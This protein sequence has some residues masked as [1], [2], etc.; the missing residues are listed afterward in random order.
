[1]E[2]IK[3]LD[4]REI[5]NN[6]GLN[7]LSKDFFFKPKGDQPFA[8]SEPYRTETYGIALVLDG[9]IE[10]RADLKHYYVKSPSII[11]MGPEIIR[12]WFSFEGSIVTLNVFF[13]EQF[14]VTGKS[15]VLFLK[16]FEFF[17]KSGTHYL[18]IDKRQ[19]KKFEYLF[20]L[21]GEK[22]ISQDKFKLSTI[23]SLT[24]A[25]LFEIEE[26][27]QRKNQREIRQLSPRELLVRKFMDLLV[28]KFQKH[29]AVQFYADRLFIN[30]KYLSQALKTE[31]GM[32]AS[33]WINE[34]VMLEAKVLLQE[35]KLTIKQITYQ[36]NFADPSFFG[37]FFKR[38]EGK[39]PRQYRDHLKS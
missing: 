17:G 16:K 8:E 28:E 12:Q 19:L 34:M 7:G 13:K 15:D 27:Y 14:L 32:T 5:E 18:S 24:E 3:R 29:R 39:S 38:H 2:E 30:S 26:I 6:F 4:L 20:K 10:L 1:M 11:V 22:F 9:E 37:K 36:L 35:Y 33:E 21:I 23:R 25:L 31:T